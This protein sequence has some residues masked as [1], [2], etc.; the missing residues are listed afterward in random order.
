M[1]EVFKTIFQRLN[2]GWKVYFEEADG[3]LIP[4][5]YIV[6]KLP[7][8]DAEKYRDNLILEVTLW[9]R[10]GDRDTA[11]LDQKWSDIDKQLKHYVH[12]DE[13]NFMKFEKISQGMIPD[14]DD[15][16]RRRELRY[17]IKR[18]ERNDY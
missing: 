14:P 3:T 10:L 9:S 4:D 6:F 18:E 16:V 7:P 5:D 12:L 11:H 2:T 17:L 8:A 1:I 13:H 15:N